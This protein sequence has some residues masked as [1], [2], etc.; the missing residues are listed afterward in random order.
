[1]FI[2]NDVTGSFHE[3]VEVLCLLEQMRNDEV[4]T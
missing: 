3:Q 1:M 4:M 2:G